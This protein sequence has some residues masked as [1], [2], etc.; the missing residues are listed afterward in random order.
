MSS[1]LVAGTLLLA[2]LI[3]NVWWW[4]HTRTI[5]NALIL[6]QERDGRV[7]SQIRQSANDDDES[8][9]GTTSGA[10]TTLAK[11]AA[12]ADC[13][14][15]ELPDRIE[16]LHNRIADL[17]GETDHLRDVWAQSWFDLFDAQFTTGGRPHVVQVNLEDGTAA[18]A[19]AFASVAQDF[20]YDIVIIAAYADGA[21]TV[22]VDESVCDHITADTIV[23]D[24]VAAA[25]GDGGGSVGF[26]TGGGCDP[27]RLSNVIQETANRLEAELAESDL[28]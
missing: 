13:P 16:K 1:H 3:T 6:S 9:V 12:Q 11:A 21:V 25:G 28:T 26:A 2:L 15:E 14:P 10:Q 20:G 22:T 4:R 17:E 24:I 23:A 5:R 27:E 7:A 19:Q 8:D 18:A